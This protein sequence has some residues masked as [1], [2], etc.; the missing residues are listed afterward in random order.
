MLRKSQLSI[1]V[2]TALVSL[3][4]VVLYSAVTLQPLY[5]QTMMGYPALAAGWAVSPR[6]LG[7][8]LAMPLVGILTVH[9]DM[10]KLI[11]VGF[12]LFAVLKRTVIS[13]CLWS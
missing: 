1:A 10:R 4:G 8:L 7:A 11:G 12:V 13:F 5:L 2:G 9:I 6:G 3:L